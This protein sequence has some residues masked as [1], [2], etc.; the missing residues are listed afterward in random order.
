MIIKLIHS[1]SQIAQICLLLSMLIWLWRF[2]VLPMEH[3]RLGPF[4]ILTL[5]VQSYAVYLSR[6]GIPNLYLLH[7][8]T[9]LEL[10]AWSFFYGYLF[11]SQQAFQKIFPWIVLSATVLIIANT[12]FLEP[13]SGFNSNAKSMVQLLLIAA[14]IF[15]FFL[16]FGK[17]DLALALPR[18]LILLNF[19]V[20][21]YYSGS[22]FIFMF[23][24]LL[25]DNNVAWHRHN[26]FWGI[27]GLL[28]VFFQILLL[29]SLW[30][31]AFR[32]MRS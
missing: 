23:A 1:C 4:I 3:R 2:R 26:L 32:K 15:Y 25:S 5:I 6:Q 21:L 24:K 16:A 17:I 14:A 20:I 10:L 19:A 18:S 30:T 29:L 13:L 27:N 28:H 11:R 9:L 22:L 8:Y 12:L 31:V 7:L